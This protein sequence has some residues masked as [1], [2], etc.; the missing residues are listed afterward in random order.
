MVTVDPEAVRA[1]ARNLLADTLRRIEEHDTDY[2][3]RYDL[4]WVAVI[5]ARRAGYAAGVRIDPAEPDW[6][7]VHIE[8]PTGQVT[9]HMPQHETPWDGHDTPEKYRRVNKFVKE[10]RV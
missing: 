3:E 4:V 9:W 1:V 6:P 10:H 5:N 2:D 8:L 7:V